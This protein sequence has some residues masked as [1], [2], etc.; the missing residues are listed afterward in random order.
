M[1]GKA[2]RKNNVKF[3]DSNKALQ[4]GWL[5]KRNTAH[6]DSGCVDLN[7]VFHPMK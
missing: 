4:R 7:L 3:E 6:S 1:F 2:G 5:S